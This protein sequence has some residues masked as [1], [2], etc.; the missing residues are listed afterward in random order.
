MLNGSYG[1]TPPD[2]EGLLEPDAGRLARP[3]PRGAGPRNGPGLPDE[4]DRQ[5]VGLADDSLG[6]EAWCPVPQRAVD[7]SRRVWTGAVSAAAGGAVGFGVRDACCALLVAVD[8]GVA[9][10]RRVRPAVR[11][12]RCGW[13]GRRVRGCSASWAWSRSAGSG[14]WIAIGLSRAG[15]FS[16]ATAG[17]SWHLDALLA[18]GLSGAGGT[19]DAAR[20]LAEPWGRGALARP[21][22]GARAERTSGR[23][24]WA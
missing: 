12:G 14:W 1:V 8:A 19:A 22:S 11:D 24:G 7:V 21:G 2:L 20:E 16:W 4:R 9:R 5:L 13:G 3:V 23:P 17:W 18:G 15:R 10:C 6:D